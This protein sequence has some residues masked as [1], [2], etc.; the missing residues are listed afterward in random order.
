MVSPLAPASS[1]KKRAA[2]PASWVLPHYEHRTFGLKL[3]VT[4]DIWGRLSSSDHMTS[5]GIM[6]VS[7]SLFNIKT[8]KTTRN[9]KL[10]ITGGLVSDECDRVCIHVNLFIICGGSSN[11]AQGI[12][13][14]MSMSMS[15]SCVSI[16][17]ARFNRNLSNSTSSG[18]HHVISPLPLYPITS[19]SI[20][21][22]YFIT[23]R[24]G[25]KCAAPFHHCF[26][27][28]WSYLE[29]VTIYNAPI[30]TAQAL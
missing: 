29:K 14:V 1:Y 28:L 3:A 27:L 5:H 21:R 22:S 9:V 13:D 24:K 18:H 25:L 23:I 19:S 26:A 16:Y 10:C 2:I 7:L 20:W 12:T 6:F 17:D 15:M 11:N 4:G 30:C 8:K